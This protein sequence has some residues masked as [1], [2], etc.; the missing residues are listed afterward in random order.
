MDDNEKVAPLLDG[1]LWEVKA[2][3]LPLPSK[4]WRLKTCCCVSSSR[5]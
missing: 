1:L 3:R 4:R 2:S 5:N